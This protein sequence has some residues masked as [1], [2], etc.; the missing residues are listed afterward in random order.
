MHFSCSHVR[1]KTLM[2]SDLEMTTIVPEMPFLASRCDCCTLYNRSAPLYV[3]VK[4]GQSSLTYVYRWGRKCRAYSMRYAVCVLILFCGRLHCQAAQ[5]LVGQQSSCILSLERGVQHPPL[6]L[7]AGGIMPPELSPARGIF[8][9]SISDMVY[10]ITH[11][12]VLVVVLQQFMPCYDCVSGSAPSG[13][14]C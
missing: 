11:L 1:S 6:V 4:A 10:H 3:A 14:N 12:V 9:V 8:Y 5:V 13:V 7:A 2:V